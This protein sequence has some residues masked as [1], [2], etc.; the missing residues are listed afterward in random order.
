MEVNLKLWYQ[1]D[2]DTKYICQ[3]RYDSNM[4]GVFPPLCVIYLPNGVCDRCRDIPLSVDLIKDFVLHTNFKIKDFVDEKNTQCS[5]LTTV[6]RIKV[7]LSHTYFGCVSIICNCLVGSI[8]LALSAIS[9]FIV[10]KQNK[11][12]SYFSLYISSC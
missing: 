1:K 12:W 8:F 7:F 11:E 9:L 6:F 4:Q 3:L 10:Y 2:F 5:W